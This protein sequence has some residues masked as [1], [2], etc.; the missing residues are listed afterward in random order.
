MNPSSARRFGTIQTSL[1]FWPALVDVVTI[2]LMIFI[3]QS[4]LQDFTDTNFQDLARLQL[5]QQALQRALEQEFRNEVKAQAVGI[6]TSPNL[7]QIRFS[8]QLLFPTG[9]YD[10]RP[11]G[12]LVLER[13][14]RVLERPDLNVYE[15]LQIEGH[16]DNAPLVSPT[17][18]RNNWDLSSARAL[19]VVQKMIDGGIAP[20]KL[21]ANGYAEFR[22]VASNADPEGQQRNRRIELRIVFRTPKRT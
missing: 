1:E 22:P 11:E 13:C 15:Q 8:E 4:F 16:T 12:L 7:L 9:G 20:T 5:T 19:S 18:P 17:Y 6:D 2:V 21:S 3:L 14:A 10:L